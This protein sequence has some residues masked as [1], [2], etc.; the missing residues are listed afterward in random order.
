LVDNKLKK[1][2]KAMQ[3]TINDVGINISKF[4]FDVALPDGGG[5]RYY[6]FNNDQTGF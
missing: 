4:F 3:N 5:Y 2:N 6:K 1:S